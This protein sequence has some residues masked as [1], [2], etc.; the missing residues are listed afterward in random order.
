MSRCRAWPPVPL[1]GQSSS[2]IAQSANRDRAASLVVKANVLVSTTIGAVPTARDLH[3]G[4]VIGF[5]G[6][7]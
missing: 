5:G 3:A 2:V 1:T 7:G 4:R 6:H